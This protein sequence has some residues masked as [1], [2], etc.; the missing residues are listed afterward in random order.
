PLKQE[1]FNTV[2]GW[3]MQGAQGPTLEQQRALK[4]ISKKDR[5]MIEKWEAFL[6]NPVPK[7]RM[8][9]RYL[10][11]HLFLAHISF[12]TG[13]NDFYELVRSTTGPGE[14]IDIIATVRPY[15]DPGTVQFYYRFRKIYST[16]V[17]K[18]HMVFPL[19]DKQYRR[20]NELFINPKWIQEPYVVDY[21][22]MRSANPFETY[23]QIPTKSRYQWLLDNAQYTIMTFIRG[24]VCKGQVALN[25]INDHFW[26]MFLDPEYDL[27]VKFP[28]FIKQHYNNL[29]MPGEN[30]SDY[31]L[32]KALFKTNTISGLLTIIR[33]DSSSMVPF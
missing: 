19:D 15:D 30:G 22:T 6:N 32:G 7:Y 20:I 26:L 13:T 12:E 29:R 25:V 11:D 24:P 14:E 2:A 8:T 5:S 23:E 21:D 9:A 28:G 18:T 3:L 1:E 31:R 27:S 10:Y 4:A 17:H 33:R 16:I